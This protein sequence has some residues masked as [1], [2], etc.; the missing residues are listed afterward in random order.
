MNSCSIIWSLITSF[1]GNITFPDD[2]TMTNIIFGVL[3]EMKNILKYI[4]S[5]NIWIIVVIACVPLDL[6]CA[7]PFHI[8]LAASWWTDW[9]TLAWPWIQQE[10][11]CSFLGC[12]ISAFLHMREPFFK[13]WS[14]TEMFAG[15]AECFVCFSCLPVAN[16]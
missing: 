5:L 10:C 13:K 3:Y 11:W 16:L 7:V 1:L 2:S 6:L 14:F 12:T 4:F 15:Q 8:C 9:G